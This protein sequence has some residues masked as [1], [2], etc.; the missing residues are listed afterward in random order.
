MTSTLLANEL[1]HLISEAKRKNTELR[2]A[3]EKSLAELKSLTVTSEQ[4]LVTGMACSLAWDQDP[5]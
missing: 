3:A 4:Q 5:Y 1:S 2:N